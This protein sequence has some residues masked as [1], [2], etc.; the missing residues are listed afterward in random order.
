M[1]DFNSVFIPLRNCQQYRLSEVPV[2][3]SEAL[4]EA[5]AEQCGNGGHRISAFFA[6]EEPGVGHRLIAILAD[7][8]NGQLACGSCLLRKPSMK[9]ISK[10]CPQAQLFEREIAE[11]FGI[12]VEGHPRL[13]PVRFH[14]AFSG[15]GVWA[16]PDGKGMLPSVIPFKR[17]E[18]QDVHEVA[19]G[20]VHAGIIEPG[21]FRFQCH[22]E[23]VFNLEISLGYQHR[24]IEKSLVGAPDWRSIHLVET[25]AGD[26]TVAHTTAYCQILEALAPAR[27][28]PGSGLA[29]RAVLL[30]LE[31]M[32]NHAGDIGALA[33]DVAF[34][35]TSSYCG[36]IRG[37]FLNMTAM[38]CGNR[39]GRGAVV[40]GG[41]SRSLDGKGIKKLEKYFTDSFND[42]ADA[43]GLLFASP[44][45]TERFE[46]CGVLPKDLAKAIGVVGPAARASGISRD[47]RKDFPTAE[48]IKSCIPIAQCDSGDV[49]ARALVR[50]IEAENS[51]DFILGHLGDLVDHVAAANVAEPKL[52]PDSLVISLVEGWRGE[53]CHV[54]VTGKDGRFRRYKIVDPSFHNWTALELVLKDE[55]IY[56]FPLCNKSFNLS[57]CGFD[58]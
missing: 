12:T 23:R 19:V 26:S 47:I 29:V 13:N 55:L 7:D 38:F 18:G 54:A 10:I 8:R 41:A 46:N 50:W 3:S 15:T 20:P 25:A 37:D 21:H 51:A 31:R 1:S 6:L 58:L 5:M 17:V 2:T 32:A 28:V 57:Y 33:N 49:H 42:L 39:F 40:P 43:A 35:P 48:Y 9:S 36:R 52:Q 44:S 22:G 34:L 56:N 53:V 45:V 11:Q 30:E 4:L 16:S 27:D 14:K 24:G